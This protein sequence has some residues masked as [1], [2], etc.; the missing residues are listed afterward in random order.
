MHARRLHAA[1]ILTDEEFARGRRRA[2]PSLRGLDA[3][4]GRRGRP[5]GD[6]AAA[7]TGR[8]ED[9]CRP[10]AQR[11][12]RGGDAPLR[13]DACAEA[14]DGDR[15]ARRSRARAGRGRGGARS[16]PGYTHLQRAQPVTL[17][18]HLLAWVEMLERDR[19]RFGVRGRAGGRESRSAR[20]RSPARPCRS[21][22]AGRDAE[23]ARRGRRP[24]LRPRLP[25]RRGRSLRP[26]VADRRGARALVVV[27]VR[28]RAAAR[29]RPR[30][31]RR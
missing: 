3:R 27:R 18:W 29:R 7:R 2:A 5:L 30:P 25:L 8:P 9:P 14:I 17:G 13:R 16:M 19:A 22:A 15:G 28:V 1:G 23:L 4:R 20:V 21:P 11:P 26:P 12:G 31:A 10:L 24:R 6:R